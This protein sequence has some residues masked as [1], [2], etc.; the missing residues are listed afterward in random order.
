MI[1][2]DGEEVKLMAYCLSMFLGVKKIG[3]TCD[4]CGRQAG[5]HKYVDFFSIVFS[6]EMLIVLVSI[7]KASLRHS[8][9]CSSCS[10][11][12]IPTRQLGPVQT[13]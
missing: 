2:K 3:Y 6:D 1:K 7:G 13:W 8:Q 4:K 5:A 12:E 10:Y 11:K 9:R